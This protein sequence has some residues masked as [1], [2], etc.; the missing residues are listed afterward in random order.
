MPYATGQFNFKKK[1]LPI[2]RDSLEVPLPPGVGP[3]NKLRN[4]GSLIPYFRLRTLSDGDRAGIIE[5][6]V[7]KRVGVIAEQPRNIDIPLS[8]DWNKGIEPD[9][10]D[11]ES[12][13]LI[14]K[15]KPW[16]KQ[17]ALQLTSET[18]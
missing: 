9:H 12:L 13:S 4:D 17:C 6:A 1:H 11:Q 14:S 18:I 16:G 15:D 5:Y 2:L 8:S 7:L 3:S 10:W